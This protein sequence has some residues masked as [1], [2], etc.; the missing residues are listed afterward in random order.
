MEEE[1]RHRL[2]LEAAKAGADKKTADDKAALK[3]RVRVR[4]I[5]W[6]SV[7]CAVDWGGGACV[8]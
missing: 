3:V 4:W 8:R 5:G 7:A 6:C 1:E 2:E